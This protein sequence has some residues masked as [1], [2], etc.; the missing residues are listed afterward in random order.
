MGLDPS[1]YPGISI[2]K[3][4][5]LH[6]NLPNREPGSKPI[7]ASIPDSVFRSR[8]RRSS[9]YWPQR[10]ALHQPEPPVEIRLDAGPQEGSSQESIGGCHLG[11]GPQSRNI[12]APQA[13]EIRGGEVAYRAALA[14]AVI[15][16]ILNIL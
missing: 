11:H 4:Q 1:T 2:L 5:S 6:V 15:I 12:T 13:L 14:E 9:R 7:S 10:I 3:D 8:R 16:I